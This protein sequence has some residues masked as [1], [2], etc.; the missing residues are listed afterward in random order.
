MAP[1]RGG[2][3]VFELSGQ[4]LGPHT[5][6]CRE[7][8]GHQVPPRAPKYLVYFH[9]V[10]ILRVS[11]CVFLCN[12]W[13]CLLCG[14]GIAP[15]VPTPPT[16]TTASA[17]APCGARGKSKKNSFGR[18]SRPVAGNAPW[19]LRARSKTVKRRNPR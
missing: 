1:S 19:S 8:A 7:K 3:N 10:R 11:L 17:V 13:T 15:S 18:A 9:I 16:G 5:I 14:E 4:A 2:Q 12:D 6:L